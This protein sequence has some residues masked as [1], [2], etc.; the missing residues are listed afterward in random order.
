MCSSRSRLIM[1]IIAASEVDLPEPVGP[2]TR[3]KPRGLRVNSSSTAGS[4]ERLE[5]RDLLRDEAEGG[6][7]RAA[8][9][10]AV[11]AEA[12]DARDRVGE[13]ELLVVLEALALVVVE[14][15]V[16][17]LAGLLR[18][19]DREVLERLDLAAYADRRAGSR[20]SGGRRRP[21]LDHPGE[22]LGEVEVTH[23]RLCRHGTPIA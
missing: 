10:E 18:G 14:D 12:G 5:R 3:T 21:A 7:D 13:V 16:D 23:P 20:R 11:D 17:D 19:Q 15:A 8:L 6:A 2:V 1:S 9:E 22:H 4:A